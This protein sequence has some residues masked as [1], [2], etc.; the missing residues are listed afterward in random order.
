MK[1]KD[2]EDAI[3]A[4]NCDV[5]I[6]EFRVRK[7]QVRRC[8]AHLRQK[9]VLLMWDEF[10]HAFSITLLALDD[11]DEV[12]SE[13]HDRYAESLFDRDTTYDLHFD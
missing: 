11:K 10:G 1:I 12:T 13:F 7:N 8:L 2:Y 4:L 3:G 9:P 6:D 5:E